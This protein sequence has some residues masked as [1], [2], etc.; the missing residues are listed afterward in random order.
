M[1]FLDEVGDFP[2]AT[3][4]SMLRVLQER[5]VDSRGE[6][7]PRSPSQLRVVSATHRDLAS[8]RSSRRAPFAAISLMLLLDGFR[9]ALRAAAARAPRRISRS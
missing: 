3:Q 9:Q 4:P 1:L 8:T 6:L 5:E 7:P 2:V